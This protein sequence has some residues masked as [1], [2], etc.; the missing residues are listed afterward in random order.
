MMT[1]LTDFQILWIIGGGLLGWVGMDFLAAMM[2][3]RHGAF[4]NLILAFIGALITYT[5]IVHHS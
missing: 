4:Y 2:K 1:S 3:W 5:I